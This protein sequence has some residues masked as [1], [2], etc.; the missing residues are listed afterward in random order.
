MGTVTGLNGIN[1]TRPCGPCRN[2]PTSLLTCR[3]IRADSERITGRN[4]RLPQCQATIIGR[5]KRMHQNF[6]A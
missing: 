6:E 1:D 2:Q 3:L 4:N 5:H